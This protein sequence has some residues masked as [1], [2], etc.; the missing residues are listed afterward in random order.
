MS[1]RLVGSESW[2][3]RPPNP[4]HNQHTNLFVT[5]QCDGKSPGC[6]QCVFS[7][8]KCDGY[9]TDWTFLTHN[10]STLRRKK[11]QALDPVNTQTATPVTVQKVH[12]CLDIT[13]LLPRQ[14]PNKPNAN[15]LSALIVQS[16]VPTSERTPNM[17]NSDYTEPRLC[18]SWVEVLSILPCLNTGSLVLTRAV[19][20]LSASIL[21]RPN[22]ANTDHSST[23]HEAIHTLRKSF[24]VNGNSVKFEL[25][26]TVMCL[27]LAEVSL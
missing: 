19:K 7:G 1:A 13:P 18:G 12:T 24:G 21:S 5:I 15:H 8:L 26:P 17:Y 27:A 10:T 3:Y 9:P 6:S 23:Y 11:G 22:M 4:K 2:G 25:I 20:A 14:I 16:Y